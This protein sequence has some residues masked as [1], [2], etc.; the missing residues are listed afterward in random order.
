MYASLPKVTKTKV[1]IPQNQEV[2]TC[3]DRQVSPVNSYASVVRGSS[4]VH[5]DKPH[6]DEILILP[7]GDFLVEKRKHLCLVKVRDFSTFPNIHM[8]FFDEG[9]DDFTINVGSF[10]VMLEFKGRDICNNLLNY[11][12]LSHWI[13]E[14][15]QW[16]RNF[17]LLERLLWVDVEGVHIRA[18]STYA[19]RKIIAKQGSISHLDVDLGE[20][21]YKNRFCVLTSFQGIISEEVSIH[22]DGIFFTVQ[23]KVAQGWLQLFSFDFAKTTYENCDAQG[24]FEEDESL[25]QKDD[26]DVQSDDPFDLYETLENMQKG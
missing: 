11:E 12:G 6:V 9:F 14:K 13:V 16:D 25:H 17:V 5:C 2:P 8:H 1:F 7:S 22:V 4:N 20:D 24:P 15:R 23:I 18:W 19:F 26:H 10:W 3:V 21:V